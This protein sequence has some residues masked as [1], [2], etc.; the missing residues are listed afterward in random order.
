MATQANL[1]TA[2]NN[3]KRKILVTSALPYA[4]GSIHLGHLVEYIQTDIWVRFQKIQGHECYYVCADDAHGTP[5][6]LRAQSE[7]ITPKQ[8]IAETSKEHQ[9][10]FKDFA[11]AFDNYYSTHSPENRFFAETIYNSL[12]DAGHISKRTISQAY[13]PEKEM[14]LPDRFIKGECPKCGAADQYGDNCEVCGA[15]Y[16]PTELKNAVSAVSGVKPVEKD[17]EHFFFKL[18]DFEPMLKD[19]SLIHI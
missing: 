12:N 2:Q 6:M 8:L 7:G 16:S 11:I 9:A 18:P 17:S 5:I 19:L 3:S 14:F 15:T 10:D 4:N 1:T 13:D